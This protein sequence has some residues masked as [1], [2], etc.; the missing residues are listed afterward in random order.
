[1]P[2]QPRLTG[3]PR[4][5]E[6]TD[7]QRF[8]HANMD[9]IAPEPGRDVDFQLG[10]AS[11]RRT[12]IVKLCIRYGLTIDPNLPAEQMMPKMEEWFLDGRLPVP[13][14]ESEEDKLLERLLAKM[15]PAQRR[16]FADQK[17]DDDPESMDWTALQKYAKSKSVYQHGMDREEI[18]NGLHALTGDK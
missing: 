16:A 6:P 8:I 4:G 3:N 11:L 1:M 13:T 5:M 9:I 10:F 7:V 17:D 2:Y 12:E 15:S 18:L 14:K